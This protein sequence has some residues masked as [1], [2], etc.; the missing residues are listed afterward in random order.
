MK[1]TVVFC[2]VLTLFSLSLMAGYEDGMVMYKRGNYDQAAVFFQEVVDQAPDQY[3]GYYML[4]LCHMKMKQMEKAMTHM[5][6]A[7]DLNPKDFNVA[8]SLANLYSQKKD[9]GSAARVLSKVK[10]ASVPHDTLKFNLLYQRGVANYQ[11]GNYGEAGKDF[12]GAVRI[13]EDANA[14]YFGGLAHYKNGM[15]GQAAVY[16][17]KSLEK[18]VKHKSAQ[19][20]YV[21]AMNQKAR[22]ESGEQ[23]VNSYAQAAVEARKLA[24]RD[25]SYDNV[26]LAGETLLGAK[27]YDDALTYFEKAKAINSKDGY[28]YFYVGKTLSLMEKYEKSQKELEQALNLLPEDKRKNAHEQMAYNC[29]KL[30]KFDEAMEIYQQLGETAKASQVQKAKHTYLNNLK[31]E[32]EQKEYEKKLAEKE[33]QSQ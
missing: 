14:Y 32:K 7:Y 17:K 10:A 31:A 18:G 22:T 27:N 2:T 15:Y 1:R 33:K 19:Y 9:Y 24:E 21:Q 3:Q 12:D 11:T 30:N 28:A 6:K 5:K 8:L 4:G 20:W 29:Q 26:L 25:K 16:L 13:R 23:K